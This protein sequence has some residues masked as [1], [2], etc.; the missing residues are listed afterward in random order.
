[1]ADLSNDPRA[2]LRTRLEKLSGC[3]LR[4]SDVP[5]SESEAMI[6]RLP[7][8]R[9]RGGQATDFFAILAR[10]SGSREAER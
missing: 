10:H 1:M 9:A 2:S 3:L 6:P 4:Q 5:Q 8:R 7:W